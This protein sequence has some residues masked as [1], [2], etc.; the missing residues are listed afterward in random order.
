MRTFATRKCYTRA[1]EY[2]RI[3]RMTI[4]CERHAHAEN[5]EFNPV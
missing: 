5:R 1:G 2:I 4:F 3:N